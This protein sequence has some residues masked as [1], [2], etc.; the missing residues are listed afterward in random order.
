VALYLKTFSPSALPLQLSGSRARQSVG[1]ATYAAINF[2]YLKAEPCYPSRRLSTIYQ[3]NP[4]FRSLF[5]IESL[6]PP[7]MST[8]L[9]VSVHLNHIRSRMV[10][11]MNLNLLLLQ[12]TC[13]RTDNFIKFI[14]VNDLLL[15][16]QQ[17]G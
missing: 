7:T 10:L 15:A 14:C 13:C 17:S 5:T 16:L 2:R 4:T 1:F 6:L 12:L 8:V 11:I 3:L 9:K